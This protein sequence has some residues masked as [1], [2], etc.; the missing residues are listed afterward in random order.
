MKN[1]IKL[2]AAVILGIMIVGCDDGNSS[3]NDMVLLLV[4]AQQAQSIEAYAVH[5]SEYQITKNVGYFASQY[6]F[7]STYRSTDWLCT[8][9][10]SKRDTIPITLHAGESSTLY[11]T[12][13][14]SEGD[15]EHVTFSCVDHD[16]IEFSIYHYKKFRI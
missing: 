14:T 15:Q 13:G 11:D 9:T 12:L 2:L 4:A 10:S 5:G 7:K 1:L 8:L 6:Y 16:P 3:S